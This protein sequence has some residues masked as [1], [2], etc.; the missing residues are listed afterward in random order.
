MFLIE[1]LISKS[2]GKGAENQPVMYLHDQD[3]HHRHHLVTDS[4]D[5]PYTVLHLVHF[6]DLLCMVHSLV[7]HCRHQ[8]FSGI[9]II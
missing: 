4:Q 6:L 7:D 5:H 1:K 3:L 9:L 2:A 8:I